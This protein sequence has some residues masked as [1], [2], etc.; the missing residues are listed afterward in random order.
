M[1]DPKTR[2]DV[3]AEHLPVGVYETDAAGNFLYVNDCW[4]A[5][6]GRDADSVVG[7]SWACVVHPEDLERVVAEWRCSREDQREFS[8]EYRYLRPDGSATW[9]WCRAVELRDD[10]GEVSGY[11]GT[12]SD[13][14][15][16]A[17]VDRALEEAEERFTNAFEEAPIGMALVALDG[18][19]LRVNRALPEIVG[20]DP[21]DLLALTFQDITHPDDLQADL[22]LV[23]QMIAGERRSYRLEKRYMRAD[24]QQAWVLLSVSLVRDED[25][26]PLYFVS[27]IEDVTER[28]HAEDALREAENRFRSAF[29][30]APIGMAMTG[31]DGRFQRVN[32]A[33]CEI[34]GYSRDQLEAT[35]SIGWPSRPSSRTRSLQLRPAQP[36]LD[37]PRRR[38]TMSACCSSRP[39]IQA[40]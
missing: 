36:S 30:E 18:S 16:S 6:A 24:G 3:L 5:L 23:R 34:T 28:R 38:W 9:V 10:Q 20:H 26:N 14:V 2:F 7:E 15:V 27:Q 19:F 40:G 32:R 4:C 22:E 8:L 13:T 1:V 25:G 39:R 37:Q 33:L 31:L 17:T 11:L 12:C 29:E 35:R 21:E